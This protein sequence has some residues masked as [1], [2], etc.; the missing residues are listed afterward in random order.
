M[1]FKEFEVCVGHLVSKVSGLPL[2]EVDGDFNVGD[3]FDG[4]AEKAEQIL[5]A[6]LCA[7]EVLRE[8]GYIND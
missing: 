5:M 4:G 3:Y 1:K 7:A 8:N 6:H 2:P